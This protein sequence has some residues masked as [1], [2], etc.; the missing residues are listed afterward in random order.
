[1]KKYMIDYDE[2]VDVR[3]NI[4]NI[5]VLANKEDSPV[6]LFLHGGPGV[7][8]RHW[9]VEHQHGLAEDYTMVMWDQ[10]GSGKSFNRNIRSEK[11]DIETYIQDAKALIEFL[12]E[13]FSKK[14]LIIAG[15]SWGTV[16]GA[17]L[18]MRYPE[19]IS[20]FISQGQVVN[21]EQNELLS[22]EFCLNEAKRLGDEKAID[23]LKD[24]APKDGM[25]ADHAAMMTQRNYLTKYGGESYKVRTS[26]TKMLLKGVLKSKE[27]SLFDIPGYASGA[28]YLSEVLWPQVAKVR[29]DETIKKI[30]V[31]ILMT[32]GRHD[33]N[34]PFELAK[35]WFD[36]LE[37]PFKKW[38][39]FEDSAHSP[40]NEE[41][42]K[43][44]EA[45]KEFLSEID[46]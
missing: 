12:L 13:K 5:R 46:C 38:V 37:A 35:K 11:L 45:V 22:Y 44:Q 7:C 36:S 19:L 1:M 3:G 6:I 9:I 30:N 23:A 20:A 17:P 8:D 4:Q 39:W 26:M 40:I 14:K 16:I 25:Y 29:Y 2:W 24:I 15:H 33:Y 28:L 43:W 18:A 32:T 41:P 10:R 27:Y 31:P 21:T 42:Q 34:T